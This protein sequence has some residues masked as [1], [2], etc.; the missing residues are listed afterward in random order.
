MNYVHMSPHFPPN[1]YLFS[2]NLA[3]LGAVVLGLGDDPYEALRPELREALTDYYR[4]NDMHNYDELLRALG[5]F[6]HRYGKLARLDSHSEYWMETEARLRTD[7]NIT[8][9]R[10]PEMAQ[11]KRKSLMKAAFMRA[12]VSAARGRICQNLGEA[13]AFLTEV[14]FPVVAKPDIGVGAANTFRLD[15]LQDLERFFATKPPVDYIV[16]EFVDGIIC[17]FDGLSDKDG[18]PVFIGSLQYSQGI[19]ET[20]N[21]DNHVYF[22]THREIPPDLEEAGRRVLKEFDIRERFYHLEFFR[23]PDGSLTALEM[24]VRPPGGPAL[25]MYNYACDVDLYWG[26]ANIVL[27]NRFVDRYARKYHCCYVGRKYTKNYCHTHDQILLALGPMIVHHEPLPAV[28]SA[29]MGD[30]T[31]LLRTPDYEEM[32]SAAA[33]IQ[34]LA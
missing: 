27:N 13:L 18:N 34:E 1:Y 11:F 8:G 20:V 25:D 29:A 5:Y 15:N 12:G 14:G 6:T 22:F 30:Y 33:F 4:V 16:E 31:Y 17:T 2:V 23:R 28:F 24:N 7:F 26:W 19:M 10:I 21:E 3:R 32:L 9:P